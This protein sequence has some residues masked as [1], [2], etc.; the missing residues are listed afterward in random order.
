[1]AHA[2]L[3]FA[4]LNEGLDCKSY[5]IASQ[6]AREAILVDPL[7][8]KV[9]R[10]IQ[11]LSDQRL[12]LLLALDTHTHADHLS[13]SRTLVERLGGKTAGSPSGSVHLPLHEGDVLTLGQLTIRV[14][15]TPGHTAD[16]L[17][18]LLDDRVLSADT[19]LIGATG[20]T[21]L[22]TGDTATEWESLTRLMT[23]PD[24]TLVFPGHDYAQ[25]TH[26]TIGHERANNKRYTLGREAFIAAMSEPRKTKPA[27]IDR[28]LLHNT[29]PL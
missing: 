29:R 14:W 10:Y 4:E 8:D 27:L 26:S 12:S 11:V 5:L 15:S 24:D 21:D 28:A 25:K 17:C 7:E 9:D 3:L 23:L 18:L 2:D 16:S 1:M 22:P 6:S 19:L 20:R 13:G